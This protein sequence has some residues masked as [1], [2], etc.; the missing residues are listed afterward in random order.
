MSTTTDPIADA[1][2]RG[3]AAADIAATNG[4]PFNAGGPFVTHE[5]DPVRSG[6]AYHS[7]WMSAYKARVA[8]IQSAR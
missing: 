3:R 1:T 2:E 5:A 6:R 4:W 7:A 8:E